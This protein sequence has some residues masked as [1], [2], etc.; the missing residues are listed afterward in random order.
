MNEYIL[1]IE[2]T[3]HTFG[4]AVVDWKGKILSNVKDSYTTKSGG[5]IPIRLK[6]ENTMK[7]SP[8]RFLKEPLRR[9]ELKKNKLR[10][11]RSQMLRGWLRVCLKV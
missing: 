7:R 8:K 4:V 1:G 3:A 10:R 11:L 9:R 6:S 5:M 2:S